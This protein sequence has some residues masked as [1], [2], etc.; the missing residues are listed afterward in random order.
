MGFQVPN[1]RIW[2]E[3]YI[4]RR[5]NVSFKEGK[6]NFDCKGLLTRASQCFHW[7]KDIASQRPK[8]QDQKMEKKNS[9]ADEGCGCVCD[10]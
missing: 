4:F 6:P 2:K 3:G 10:W 5:E 8:H 1:L 7:V 9:Q